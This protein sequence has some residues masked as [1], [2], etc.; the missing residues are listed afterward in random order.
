VRGSRDP[1]AAPETLTERDAWVCWRYKFETDRD[2][3]TKVP[4][5]ADTG[6]FGKSTDPDTWVSFVTARAYHERT[7][8]D[9]DGV[10]FVVHDG[11]TVLGLDLDD[12]PTYAEVSPSISPI[13]S[14]SVRPRNPPATVVCKPILQARAL[15]TDKPGSTDT[16]SDL[17]D[18]EILEKAKNA[19][20]GEKF[21]RLWIGDTAGYPSHSEA[22]LA[23]AGLLAFW[24]GGDRRRIDHPFRRSK[25]YREKWERTINKALITE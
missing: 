10:G 22:D 11:D 14:R 16:A 20:N 21:R 2:E 8:T 7:G 24:T 23:L 3:W 4:I 19:E 12:V 1:D 9:T 13:P 6:D 17:S 18:D 15:D 5:D 25:R